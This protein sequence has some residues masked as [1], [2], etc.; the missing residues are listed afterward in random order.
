LS[1]EYSAKG[2]KKPQAKETL[3]RGVIHKKK[4]LEKLV[5]DFLHW[6]KGEIRV[7]E[8]CLRIE[9]LF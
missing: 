4:L 6:E 8:T 2:A 1:R 5:E 3:L 9:I 7:V